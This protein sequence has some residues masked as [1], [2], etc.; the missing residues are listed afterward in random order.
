MQLQRKLE[1]QPPQAAGGQNVEG[2]WG[3]AGVGAAAAGDDSDFE[4]QGDG[5]DGSSMQ[6]EPPPLATGE[7]LSQLEMH[8]KL[9]HKQEKGKRKQKSKGHERFWG[10]MLLDQLIWKIFRL[11]GQWLEVFLVESC[12]DIGEFFGGFGAKLWMDKKNV[13]DRYCDFSGART[14]V[15]SPK[16]AGCCFL[17]MEK[18]YLKMRKI[19]LLMFCC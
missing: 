4:E 12:R 2:S 6:M 3:E 18:M 5:D 19:M 13:H 16:S 1:E 7:S 10:Q 15:R 11:I 8:G 14:W 9:C 17:L